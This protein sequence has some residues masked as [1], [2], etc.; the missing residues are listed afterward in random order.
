M[1]KI[2]KIQ[3][4][5]APKAVGPYSQ[6]VAAAEHIF[7]SGQIPIDPDSG[8]VIGGDIRAQT[9]LVIDNTRKI[10]GSCGLDLGRVVKVDIFLKDLEDFAVMNEV[11]ASSFLKEPR[12]ARCVVQVSRL[13]KDVRIEMSCI[14]LRA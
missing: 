7:V 6:A 2:S 9:K 8:D 1:E 14:A 3:C 10:L 11:Y 13:P 12:P 5:D 4:S